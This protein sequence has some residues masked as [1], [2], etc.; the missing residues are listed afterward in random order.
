[1][2]TPARDAL[3]S[4]SVDSKKKGQAFGFH[5]AMD[6]LGALGGPLLALIVLSKFEGNIRLVFL[7]SAIPALLALVFI[8][9]T[10]EKSL[11]E[12]RESYPPKETVIRNRPLLIFIMANVFFSLGNSSNAFLIL[13]VRE[14]GLSI[15]LIPVIW[16]VYNIFCTISSPIFGTLSD[17]IDRKTII[18]ISFLYYSLLYYLFGISYNLQIL[19]V[20][21][22]AY[23]LY[24]GLSEGIYRAYIADLVPEKK[25]ATAFGIFNTAIGLA[26]FPASLIMGVLWD[27]FGSQTAFHFSALFSLL[28]F[29]IFFISS[30][31]LKPQR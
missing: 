8:L 12:Q 7:L 20:L 21:F 3:L 27:Q 11:Q 1:M 26:L 18:S 23:G 16:M 2:R 6:R 24:Y 10:R 13:K 28:G 22:A 9:F 15:A 17:K 4:S 19:W 29:I 14:A 5:R 25:R 31:L 30:K